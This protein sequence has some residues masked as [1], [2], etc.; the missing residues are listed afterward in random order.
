VDKNERHYQ[1]R[2]L[3]E[4]TLESKLLQAVKESLNS[5]FAGFDFSVNLCFDSSVSWATGRSSGL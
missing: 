4:S 3:F 1:H 2:N 5:A